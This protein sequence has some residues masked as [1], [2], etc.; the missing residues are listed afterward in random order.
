MVSLVSLVHLDS[1]DSLEPMATPETLGRRDREATSAYR[2]PTAFQVV[3]DRKDRGEVTAREARPEIPATREAGV[4][5]DSRVT[6]DRRDSR[7]PPAFAVRKEL[8]ARWASVD[9]AAHR[10]NAVSQESPDNRAHLEISAHPVILEIPALRA[11][12]VLRD[13]EELLD[14]PETLVVWD[15][16]ASQDNKV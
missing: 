2:A 7:V 3:P 13:R 11:H 9:L 10:D 12:E 8:S 1:E 4:R 6:P 15:L 14:F 16:L 5:R